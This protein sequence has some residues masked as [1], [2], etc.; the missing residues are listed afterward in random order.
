[1]DKEKKIITASDLINPE[2]VDLEALEGKI[3]H[4]KSK[5]SGLIERETKNVKIITEDGRELLT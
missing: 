1:M 2:E 3:K 5:K 4:I